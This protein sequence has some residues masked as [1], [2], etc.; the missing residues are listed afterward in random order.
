MEYKV[1]S[2]DTLWGIAKEYNTTVDKLVE[3]NG[4]KNRNLIYTGDVLNIPNSRDTSSSSSS[5]FTD[6]TGRAEKRYEEWLNKKPAEFEDK[7]GDEIE[8][9]RSELKSR[10]FSYDPYSSEEYKRQSRINEETAEMALADA[11]GVASSM[12]GG[13]LSSYA[14]NEGKYA[15]LDEIRKNDDLVRELYDE[16]YKNFKEESV[17]LED[18]LK[19]LLDMKD[20]EW[21]RYINMIDTFYEEGDVLF[22]QFKKLSDEDFDRFYS[23]Y[24]LS[25]K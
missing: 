8:A 25:Q 21:K 11:M 3:A 17:R 15:Y 10:K 23:V 6:I 20:D 12:T 4:I 9:V 18:Q 19:T 2:G 13:Y 22:E 1:K 5:D 24:K 14:V 16:A 7:Y